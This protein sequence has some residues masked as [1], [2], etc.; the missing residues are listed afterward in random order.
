[1]KKQEDRHSCL[2]QPGKARQEEIVRLLRLSC[3]VLIPK[4]FRRVAQGCRAATTLGENFSQ[5]IYPEGVA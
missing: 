3:V 4:G 1:M 5:H 2:S